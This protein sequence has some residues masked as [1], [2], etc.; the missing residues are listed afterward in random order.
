V[1]AKNGNTLEM[2]LA[3]RIGSMRTDR[4]KVKQCLLNVLSNASKFTQDGKLTVRVE[5]LETD[6]PMIQMTISD[7]GIGM[8]PEQLGRLFQAFSQADASNAD[9]STQKQC[10]LRSDVSGTVPAAGPQ[11]RLGFYTGHDLLPPK[12][13]SNAVPTNQTSPSSAANAQHISS[14]SMCRVLMVAFNY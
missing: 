13:N 2:R 3:D 9:H 4:T 12:A 5:R 14:R 1:V 8:T 11:G 7:T 6:R 10:D